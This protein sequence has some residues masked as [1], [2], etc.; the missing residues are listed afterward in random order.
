MMV[1]AVACWLVSK[2][3]PA[4][5]EAAPT[6]KIDPNP[7]RSSLDLMKDL[8][9][10]TRLWR[11]GVMVALFWLI[12]ALIV[13]LAPSLIKIMGGNEMVVTVYLAEFSIAI[14][15]GSGLGSFLS[16]GR[17]VLLPAPIACFVIGAVALDVGFMVR[18]FET[19][20]QT[21][22]GRHS[23]RNLRL[24]GSPST[25]QSWPLWAAFLSCPLSRRSRYGRQTPSARASSAP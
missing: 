14:A 9:A 7:L 13:S 18:G 16:T 19:P 5:A 22:D 3:I 17:V 8:W 11:A 25:L 6:L 2:A 10:D 4:T 23:S 15:I 21:L 20:A 24:G 1:L 12:G